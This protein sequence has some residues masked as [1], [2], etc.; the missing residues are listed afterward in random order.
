MFLAL[1]YGLTF[2]ATAF[3]ASDSTKR[4]AVTFL[5]LFLLGA[6]VS[7]SRSTL[8]TG[9]LPVYAEGFAD[10]EW[11]FYYLR[12]APFWYV[13]RTLTSFTGSVRTTF[14][15]IDVATIFLLTR[16]FGGRL[17]IQL[18][19][20]LFA[21]PSILGFT[22]I[23]RQL[24]GSVLMMLALRDL[25]SRRLCG[26]LL[27]A[28]AS[29]V[30]VALVGVC[31]SLLIACLLRPGNRRWLVIALPLLG[32]TWINIQPGIGLLDVTGGT[33]SRGDTGLLYVILGVLVHIV[34]TRL[35]WRDK[36]LRTLHLGLLIYFGA[37][38]ASLAVVPDSTGTR[39]MM[40][41]LYLSSF[42][43]LASLG[44]ARSKRRS[45]KI[46]TLALGCLLITPLIVSDS[47]W[48]LIFGYVID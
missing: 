41:S 34:C 28:F 7:I 45:A 36:R 23:Y 30:H 3:L 6:M 27:A 39:V 46:Y 33:E 29:T 48:H 19:V 22:N 20:L 14:F 10:D 31:L 8:N 47:A 5:P 1:F 21:F 44:E 2:C 17:N 13:G 15:L 35:L 11:T 42:L 25:R 9:D 16:A 32:L 18:V 4:V 38:A 24:I 40:T 43:A 37:G 26:V 12:E